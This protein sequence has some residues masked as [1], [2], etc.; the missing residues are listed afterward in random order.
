MEA[1]IKMED[2]KE[3]GESRTDLRM[4]KVLCGIPPQD[5][6]TEK[7]EEIQQKPEVR[8]RYRQKNGRLSTSYPQ[9]C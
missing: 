1:S 8:K 5:Q 3:Q 9:K 7:I 2:G 6:S 4:R